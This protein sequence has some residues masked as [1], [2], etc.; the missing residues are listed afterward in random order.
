VVYQAVMFD[1]RVV[2]L[3]GFLTPDGEYYRGVTPT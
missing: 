1:G 3:A 2:G